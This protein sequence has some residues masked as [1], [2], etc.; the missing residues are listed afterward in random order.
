MTA[1]P[2]SSNPTGY[3][4][5]EI[6]QPPNWHGMV[7][8]D[9]FLNGLTA[10]LFLVTA[11]GN[12]TRPDLFAAASRWAYLVAMIALLADLT[13]LVLDLGDPTRFHH[14]LRVFKPLSPMSLGT[15]C[16]TVYSLPI[17]AVVALDLAIRVEWLPGDSKTIGWIQGALIVLG[18][19]FAF[20]V[21]AY[22]GVLFSTTAQPGWRDA[23]WLGAYHTSGGLMLGAAA[24][25]IV[26]AVTGNDASV[27]AT[28]IALGALTVLNLVALALLARELGPT[29]ARTYPGRRHNQLIL[30]VIFA[31]VVLPLLLLLLGSNVALVGAA[32][33][34][35]TIGLV[36]RSVIVRLPHTLHDALAE[37]SGG[38]ES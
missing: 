9:M 28:R 17:T 14:M 25:S 23:R 3:A 1:T 33:L 4:R 11:L 15:W 37:E 7:V 8:W 29:L 32:L 30:G 26:A 16:L 31:G 34:L 24:L 2:P 12:L 18:M 20:G 6:S 38:T 13:L 10:G 36:V 27:A 21:L 19:P 22:K 35:L 5:R